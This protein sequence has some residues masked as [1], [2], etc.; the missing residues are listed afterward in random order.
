M[1]RGLLD[2]IEKEVSEM[3]GKFVKVWSGCFLSVLRLP[4][5]G[6]WAVDDGEEKPVSSD[7]V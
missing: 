6:V 1:S 3:E 5:L 7:Q 4:V 2:G